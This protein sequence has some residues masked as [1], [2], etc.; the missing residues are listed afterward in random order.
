MERTL[1]WIFWIGVFDPLAS[2]MWETFNIS[3]VTRNVNVNSA[4]TMF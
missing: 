3:Q 1:C 2:F 4:E